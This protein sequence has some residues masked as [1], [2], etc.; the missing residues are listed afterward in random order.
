MT[1]LFDTLLAGINN[2]SIT[3]ATLN[4]PTAG[5]RRVPLALDLFDFQIEAVE[6]ALR[7]TVNMPYG[8]IGLDM[9]LGKTPCGISCAASSVAAG[10][11]PVLITVPPAMRRTWER[12]LTKFAPWLT[13]ATITGAEPDPIAVLPD[14]DVLIIG[15][16]AMTINKYIERDD[17][18]NRIIPPQLVKYGWAEFL[19]GKIAALIVD[20]AHFY[21]NKSTRSTA[22]RVIAESVPG[23]RILMSGTPTPNGRH[24]EL[25][26][27]VDLMG[28]GAWRDIGGK[29]LFWQHYAPTVD[30]YSRVNN[31]GAALYKA[32]S[33][34]WFHRRLRDDVIELP[35]KGRTALLAEGKGM[36]VKRYIKAE[37]D[38]IEY[39]REK[40]NGVVSQG[41][42]RAAALIK[43]MTLR[44]LAGQAKVKAVIEHVKEM[45]NE[46]PG[47]V[48]IVA[49]HKEV[50]DDLMLGL[51]KFNPSEVRGG[52]SDNG[53]QAEIDDFVSGNCR[54][55]IGQV[56]AVG[57]GLTLHGG[58][59]N[60]RVVI[61]QL[62]WTP[63]DL[64]QAEDRLHRIG[65][66]HDVMVE[67][68]LCNIDGHVTIDERL[69]GMLERKNFDASMICDGEG[70]YLLK[71]IQDGVLDSYR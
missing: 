22:L 24:Q 10:Q 41:Q 2:P 47:G 8:Y 5:L 21:K 23:I 60:H 62:P 16:S 15:S 38:L 1:D 9:G 27:Q 42:R 71:A 43:L 55:L 36:A 28:A 64:K 70:E 59:K 50:I 4:M 65:Q 30:Q 45:L 17:K 14:V 34:T 61:A 31:D 20:E 56:T 39:L 11:R 3:A 54:V 49:E 13:V 25:A 37:A 12:E 69:W 26:Y 44:Q 66:T 48:L 57:V 46:E 52:Q 53:R 18:G 35:A 6:H 19:S 7:D 32:M 63:A 67:V 40:Q 51:S 58:G 33:S 68:A 29:G